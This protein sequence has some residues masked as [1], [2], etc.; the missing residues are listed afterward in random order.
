MYPVD[1]ELLSLKKDVPK[2]LPRDRNGKKVHQ[3]T[4]RRWATIGRGGHRLPVLRISGSLYTTREALFEFLRKTTREEGKQSVDAAAAIQDGLLEAKA[5]ALRLLPR[6][7]THES[8]VSPAAKGVNDVED[9][10]D[11][12]GI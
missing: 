12:Y 8:D 6:K 1:H 10:P 2:I 11:P 9:S 3:S 7:V 5:R 4:L